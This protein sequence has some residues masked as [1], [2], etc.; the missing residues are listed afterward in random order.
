MKRISLSVTIFSIF[1]VS[2]A[3]AQELP[4]VRGVEAQ[5]FIAQVLRLEEAL[6]FLGSSLAPEDE[7]RLA[8]GAGDAFMNSAS[9]LKVSSVANVQSA[10]PSP[11]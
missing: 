9:F 10:R 2:E 1:L 11:W 8:A 7:A 5:P 6:S 4:L 3:F